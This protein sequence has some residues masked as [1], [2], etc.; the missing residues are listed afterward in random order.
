MVAIPLAALSATPTLKLTVPPPGRYGVEDLWKVTVTADTVCDAWF[1]GRVFEA[2][3]GQ[4]FHAT[5]K[6]FRLALGTR[7]YQ[8]RDVQIDKTETAAGYETFVTRSGQ[9]PAGKYRFKLMLQPFGV[10]DS[11]QF[12][13]KPMGSPR[14]ILPRQGETIK[15]TSPQFTWTPP[16][17]LPKKPVTYE[18]RLY[19]V[20]PGQT[21][22][23]AAA[24]NPAWF[25]QAGITGPRLVYPAGARPL[26]RGASYAW[27]VDV[28]D[29]TTRVKL[30]KSD[31]SEFTAGGA[32]GSGL[33]TRQQVIDVVLAQVVVPPT[34]NHTARVFLGMSALGRG[35]RV[36]PF[37]DGRERI[38]DRPTWFSWVDDE[39]QA[40]FSHPT[41]YVFVDAYTGRVAV[42]SENWWPVVNDVSLWMSDKEWTDKDL[43]IYSDVNCNR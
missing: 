25:E 28:L 36:R 39:P 12:E 4:V 43:I 29:A 20:L 8:Y 13:V 15:T 2:T 37:Y 41:R 5:T 21:P 9:L 33:L 38:L 16:S 42:T 22:K 19:E 32:G 24:S 23:E 27:Q 11:N 18:L 40:F 3:H 6:P 10:G 14:L 30:A 35:D 7:L 26:D 1:E 31:V 34:L 17:P